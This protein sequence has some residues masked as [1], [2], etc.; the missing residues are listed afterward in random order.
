MHTTRSLGLRPVRGLLI[1]MALARSHTAGA[2]RR[3]ARTPAD[4]C[5]DF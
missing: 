5:A 4:P 3:R 2:S 1:L